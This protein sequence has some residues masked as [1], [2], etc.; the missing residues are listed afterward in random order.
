M[1]G[2]KSLRSPDWFEVDP[3]KASLPGLPVLVP[4]GPVVAVLLA[5]FLVMSPQGLRGEADWRMILVKR[6]LEDGERRW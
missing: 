2:N 1:R 4:E 3:L 6:S 5:S